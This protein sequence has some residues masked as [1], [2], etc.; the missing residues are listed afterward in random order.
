MG[1]QAVL[2]TGIAIIVNPLLNGTAYS[3][4]CYGDIQWK[5]FQYRLSSLIL[6]LS[7]SRIRAKSMNC[8]RK[9]ALR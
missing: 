2:K 4:R 5:G 8:C 6:L 3:F 9:K 7:A 1:D